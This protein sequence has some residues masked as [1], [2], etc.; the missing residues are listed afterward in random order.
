MTDHDEPPM[1]GRLPP[2]VYLVGSLTRFAQGLYMPFLGTYMVDMGASYGELSA[3]RSV[4]NIAPTILQPLWGAGSDKVGHTKAFVV[5]GTLTGLF[6]VYLF[7]WASTPFE[8]IVL[9]AI[10]SLLLSIQIPT[11]LSLIGG[12]MD[13]KYR[14]EELGKLT[15]V[16]SIASLVATLIAGFIAGFPAVLPFVRAMLGDWGT[17]LLPPVDQWKEIYYIPFYVTALVGIVSSLIA[18]TIKEKPRNDSVRRGFPPMFRLLSQPGDFR[19]LCAVATFFSF[20]MSMAWPYFVVVQRVWL[21]N[22]LLEIAIASAIMSIFTVIFTT[23]LGRLSDRVGRKP[24]I[25]IGRGTLFLVPLLYAFATTTL[26]IYIANAIAGFAIAGA[27]NALTAYIYDISPEDERGAY[28]SVYNTFTGIVFLSGTFM[29]GI[30]GEWFV[31]FL[32][33]HGAV[34]AMLVLSGVLRFVAA[35]MFVFLREPRQYKSTLRAEIYAFLGR[36][37]GGDRV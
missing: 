5:F 1:N 14:G 19:R 34:F 17:V 27:F 7:L 18:L 26:M 35:F 11:W 30:L 2:R 13:E 32:G 10:Q 6:T 25:L 23:P 15:M 22:T 12:L 9:Y 28:L 31:T 29:A 4:G 16:T 36:R 21:S 24:L 33:S 8:M 20:A 3:F 37:L